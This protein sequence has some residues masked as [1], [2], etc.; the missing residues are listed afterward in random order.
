MESVMSDST[1]QPSDQRPSQGCAAGADHD[2]EIP[3]IDLL[4]PA[5]F[6]GVTLRNRIVMSPMC[7]CSAIEGKANDW[8]LVHLGSRAAGGVGDTFSVNI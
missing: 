3:E 6:R 1:T 2:R 5:T 4:T 8:H 7:Q